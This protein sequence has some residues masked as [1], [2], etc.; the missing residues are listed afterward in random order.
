MTI[1]SDNVLFNYHT[2]STLETDSSKTSC[3]NPV[4]PTPP[5]PPKRLS[6]K[7]QKSSGTLHLSFLIITSSS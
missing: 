2:G 1:A 6:S 4:L 7:T 3:N 5:Q